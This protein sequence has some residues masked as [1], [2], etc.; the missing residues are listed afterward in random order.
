MFVTTSLLKLI[1][2]V[3]SAALT[4]WLWVRILRQPYN[5]LIK[6]G[7]MC[8]VAIPYLGPLLWLFLDVPSKRSDSARLPSPYQG[9]TGALPLQPKWAA[10][11]YRAI[12]LFAACILLV[13]YIYLAG[14]IVA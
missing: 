9:P 13:M 10:R 5:P 14:V 6:A 11:G 3:G 12:L 8:V 4:V 1:A 2:L 7:Q